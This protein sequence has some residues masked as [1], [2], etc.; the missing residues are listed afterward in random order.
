MD[1]D[2]PIE[3]NPPQVLL[4]NKQNEQRGAKSKVSF[5]FKCTKCPI[6]FTHEKDMK[7]HMTI[8]HK[9]EED[10]IC[11]KCSYKTKDLSSLTIH[12]NQVHTNHT[13]FKALKIIKCHFCDQ[14][15]ETKQNLNEHMNSNHTKQ[16]DNEVKCDLCD[17]TFDTKQNAEIHVENEHIDDEDRYWLCSEC[18]FQTNNLNSLKRHMNV[19]KHTTNITD[20]VKCKFCESRFVTKKTV[21]DT[22]KRHSYILQTMQK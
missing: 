11:E 4:N 13:T 14:T 21:E 9:E 19:S 17:K 2:V 18:P 15:F 10:W 16:S 7:K 6:A 5:T 1:V 8:D 22:H 12:M 20:S 3:E